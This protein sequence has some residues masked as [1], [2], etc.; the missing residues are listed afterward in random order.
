MLTLELCIAGVMLISLIIYMLTGGADFGGG[1][2]DLFATGP[3]AKSQRALI[4]QAIAPIWEGEPCLAD[5]DYR[6]AVRG[7]PRRIRGDQHGFTHSANVNAHRY[8]ASWL[9]VCVSYLR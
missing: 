1:I 5:C 6:A 2:W 4:T 3:R 8:C 9:G 7:V